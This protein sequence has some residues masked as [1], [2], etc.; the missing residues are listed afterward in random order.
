MLLLTAI[1]SGLQNQNQI[2]HGSCNKGMSH[3]SQILLL[4]KN[5]NQHTSKIQANVVLPAD[6]LT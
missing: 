2:E 6:F 1:S 5:Y 4:Q 3:C